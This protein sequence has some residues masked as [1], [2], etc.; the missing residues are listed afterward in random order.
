MEDMLEVYCAGKVWKPWTQLEDETLADLVVR[1]GGKDWQD[2]SKRLAEVTG[3]V[4][5]AK[6]CRQRWTDQ[7]DPKLNHRPFTK[8]ESELVVKYQKV[9]GNHWSLIA[10]KIGNRSANMIKNHWYSMKRKFHRLKSQGKPLVHAKRIDS[11][12][13]PGME[14]QRVPAESVSGRAKDAKVHDPAP[15]RRVNPASMPIRLASGN[16]QILPYGN[17]GRGS[18][19]LQLSGTYAPV[20]GDRDSLA[21]IPLSLGQPLHGMTMNGGRGSPALYPPTVLLST[22]VGVLNLLGTASVPQNPKMPR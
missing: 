10:T 12:P 20:M 18:H 9:Y 3:T 13:T 22:N 21:C 19:F 5:P 2:V 7:L 14:G 4:R 6:S 17:N 11:G 8:E 15:S 16:L 1:T